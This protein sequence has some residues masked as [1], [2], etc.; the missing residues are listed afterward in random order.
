MQ[1]M[2]IC[3]YTLCIVHISV[4]LLLTHCM[5]FI[6]IMH[7]VPILYCCCFFP[8]YFS[9]A[10]RGSCFTGIYGY[11]MEETQNS[12]SAFEQLIGF[13]NLI[14]YHHGGSRGSQAKRGEYFLILCNI[15][16]HRIIGYELG[17]QSIYQ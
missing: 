7:V 16:S 4:A 2:Y 15:I 13:E 5:N 14:E 17:L 11:T 8:I 9:L 10:I 3:I 12:C 6:C 1:C